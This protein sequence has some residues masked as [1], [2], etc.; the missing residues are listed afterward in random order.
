MQTYTTISVRLL[1]GHFLT[2]ST[3]DPTSTCTGIAMA[4]EAGW[5]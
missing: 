4:T 5:R 1:P 2:G 3:E